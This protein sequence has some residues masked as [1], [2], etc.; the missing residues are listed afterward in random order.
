MLR[1]IRNDLKAHGGHW[2]A[3]GFWALAVYRFGRWCLGVR[4][5]PLRRLLLV[6]YY[7]LFKLVQ[8][9]TG[10]EIYCE[11]EIGSNLVIDHA[12][13]IVISGYTR[14]GDHCR[15]RPGVVIG[16]KDLSDPCAPVIGSH[17]DIGAG[18]KLLGRITIGDNVWIGANAVVMR[19]VPAN[20]IAV[21]VPAV[22]KPRKARHGA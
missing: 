19:D 17:V 2:G 18:A 11:A 10:I 8:V 22:V 20:S 7:L 3:Q 14:M 21:G 4:P 12:G 6:G 15:I 16:L 13:G 1:E 9:A 5:A